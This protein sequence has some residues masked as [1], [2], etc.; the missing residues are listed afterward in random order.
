MSPCASEARRAQRQPAGCCSPCSLERLWGL[1]GQRLRGEE[2]KGEPRLSLAWVWGLGL[3]PTLVLVGMGVQGTVFQSKRRREG[4]GG[5]KLGVGGGKGEQERKRRSGRGGSFFWGGRVLFCLFVQCHWRCGEGREENRDWPGKPPVNSCHCQVQP[6]PQ[7]LPTLTARVEAPL[8]SPPQPAR[9][10][11]EDMCHPHGD[12]R[13]HL[14][15]SGPGN[16]NCPSPGAGCS[17]SWEAPALFLSRT[18]GD[19]HAK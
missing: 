14:K 6:Q 12:L 2:P 16:L 3:V 10:A 8:N 5:G 9:G 11:P 17:L 19:P 1:G 18:H 4:S 7:T 13:D 15:G